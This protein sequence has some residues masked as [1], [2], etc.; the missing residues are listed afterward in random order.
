MFSVIRPPVDCR[1]L[2]TM[3]VI[4][5]VMLKCF[6]ISQWFL[7]TDGFPSSRPFF[8]PASHSK[9]TFCVAHRNESRLQ[10]SRRCL[11]TGFWMKS[12]CSSQVEA[13]KRNEWRFGILRQNVVNITIDRMQ[14]YQGWLN[15]KIRTW[16]PGFYP[17][18]VPGCLETQHSCCLKSDFWDSSCSPF[19]IHSCHCHRLKMAHLNHYD[20][21]LMCNGSIY[22]LTNNSI[23]PQM[24]IKIPFTGRQTGQIEA[25]LQAITSGFFS[26]ITATSLSRVED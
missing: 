5:S 9:T 19:N 18:Q 25:R 16:W 26:L 14:Y 10:Q 20:D 21:N 17:N 2:Q 13:I 1:G 7:Q 22:W 6:E 12:R 11:E 15:S 24:T 23:S 8:A 4:V 3:F